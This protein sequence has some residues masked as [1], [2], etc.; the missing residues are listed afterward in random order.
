MTSPNDPFLSD[1]FHT[2]PA[3]VVARMRSDDP[4]HL[5]PGLNAW[6]VTRH[7]DVRGLFTNENVTND[8][9]VFEHYTLPEEG[10]TARW[11]AEN[12]PFAAPPE[13]HARMRR[14]VSS[15]LTPRAVKRMEDQVRAVV[16]DFAQPL[17]GRTG[18]VDVFAEFT[19]PIPNTVIGRIAGVPPK[20]ED[21]LRWRTLGRDAV[22]G[23]SPFLSPEERKVSEDA[24]TE[25]CDYVRELAGE[26]RKR[27]EDDLVSDLVL[28]HDESDQMTN[29]EIVLMVAGLVAAGTET[30]TIGGTRGIRALL[31]HPE[32]M[33]LLRQDRALMRNAVDELLRFDFGSLGLPRYAL[34]DFSFRGKQI[35]KGQV[36][37]LSFL[38]AHRDPDVFP[39]P[40]R[41]DIRRDVSALTI[42]GH[43][44]HYCLGANLARQELGCMFDAALDFLTPG[45]K[46]VEED[47]AWTRMGIFSRI[48][49]LP[50]ELSERP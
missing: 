7:D 13:Q 23:V 1:E 36:M 25:L 31:Q 11:I 44:P 20:G 30:T 22:R 9:R 41:L 47:I 3:A 14:L 37:L 19:E 2:D 4:V 32:Q 38:G 45:S 28:A 24:M 16:D 43:G 34:R 49:S 21:E 26:R 40:D 29:D 42:F 46:V 27:P 50:V 8:R 48:D 33:E 10:T 15:A 35:R 17:R 39:D 12:G 6:M 5:I 18:V